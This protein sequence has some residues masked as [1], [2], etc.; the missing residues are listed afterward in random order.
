[1]IAITVLVGGLGSVIG[2]FLNVVV[3]RVPLAQSVVHPPSACP[4]CGSAIRAR[5][6]IP[7]LSWVL[8]RGRC[9]DCAEPIAVRYPLVELGTAVA[10]TLVALGWLPAVL[11][12]RSVADSVSAV[13]ELVA[14]LYLAA[15]SIA[16]ALI[17]LE[18]RRLP[19][20]ILVPAIVVMAVLLTASS[21]LVGDP[22]ALARAGIGGVAL[23]LLYLGLALGT[24]GGMGLGDVKL[25]ALVGIVTGWIG[26][27]ALI[28]AAFAAFVL[29]GLIGLLLLVARRATRRSAIPF[30]P[31]MILGAWIGIVF[32]DW[33]AATYLH[34]AGLA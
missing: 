26:W 20:R 17:D 23:F 31:W 11:G 25:A 6:N 19:N 4:S 3:H 10:F 29:G 1:M 16:L 22:A 27:P 32:G 34:V 14:F 9:R 18:T 33:I 24:R 12:A 28:V 7:V 13:I 15:V 21:L 5:D 2:S 30:G 8:L